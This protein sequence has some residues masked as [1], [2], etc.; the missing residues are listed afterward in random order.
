MRPPQPTNRSY[1][2]EIITPGSYS[3]PNYRLRTPNEPSTCISKLNPSI[4]QLKKDWYA[5]GLPL[6][7]DFQ[8]EKLAGKRVL[9]SSERQA[10]VIRVVVK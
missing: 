2:E 8:F 5:V 3:H 10:P 4:F 9:V 7:D 6:L 1:H